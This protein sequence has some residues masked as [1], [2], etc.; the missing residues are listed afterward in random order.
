MKRNRLLHSWGL[1]VLVVGIARSVSAEPTGYALLPRPERADV[2]A[3]ARPGQIRY[4]RC[5][6]GPIEARKAALSGWEAIQEADAVR[7]CETFY[8]DQ[9]IRM[10]V[11]AHINWIWVTWSNGFSQETEARQRQILQ[12]WIAKCHQAGIRVT[13][14]LSL[15]NMFIDD[16]VANVPAS[17]GWMQLNADGTPRP[18]SAARYTGKITRIIACLNNPEWLEYSRLRIASAVAAGVDGIAYD[19]GFQGCTCALCRQKFADY[20]ATR[21]G[22]R[23]AIPTVKG[24]ELQKNTQ[25][26]QIV[27]DRPTT[28]RAELAWREFCLKTVAEAHTLH[29]RY[30]DALHPGILVY[31]NVNMPQMPF[32]TE[33]LNALST[34]D[35]IEPGQFDPSTAGDV[36]QRLRRDLPP[37]SAARDQVVTNIGLYKYEYAEGDGWK[38]VRIEH[39]RRIHGDRMTNPMPP[40]N[41]RLSVYEAAACHGGV[42]SFFEMGW[43][44]QLYRGEK[45]A[46]EALA[47]LGEANAW[48][49]SHASLFAEV[50]PIGRTALITHK[51]DRAMGL[52]RAGK[53]FVVLLPRH[54]RP[55]QL[56]Q[57]PLVILDNV[58]SLTAG[59]RATLADYVRQGGHLLVTGDT[60]ALDADSL[61]PLDPP[62]LTDLFPSNVSRQ[63]RAEC[64]MGQG[65]IVYEP[66]ALGSAEGLRDWSRLEGMPLVMV[67]A[68]SD[69]ICFNLVRTWDGRRVRVYL[70][71][72]ADQPARDVEVSLHLSRAA[73]ALRWYAPGGE[74]STL[75]PSAAPDGLLVHVPQFDQLGVVDIEQE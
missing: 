8:T 5:D 2:P 25:G 52:V 13:A 75:S 23:L 51:A 3:W 68:T 55:S 50:E 22:Q 45:G 58:S 40:R 35:G 14:Y 15:T 53:N 34:E 24:G 11:E 71:N 36:A 73:K 46:R 19:N 9:T 17:K 72:Y 28:K 31:A 1:L 44:T 6:G 42:E 27:I 69:A 64:R 66:Q 47:A 32:L 37:G 10:L 59:Q 41:Q 21:F 60:A 49:E 62:G 63:Q 4:A 33:G 43:T 7:A 70:L 30:A 61:Q 54:I 56:R 18:Y 57:F 12:P 74:P 38:P 16:M 26:A 48:V 65:I 67:H 39:G 20:T 29:R